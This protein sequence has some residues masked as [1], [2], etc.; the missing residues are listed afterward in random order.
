MV[1]FH[2]QNPSSRFPLLDV[3][4]WPYSTGGRS[5]CDPLLS[6]VFLK[7]EALHLGIG[8]G[9]Y[10]VESVDFNKLTAYQPASCRFRLLTAAIIF[11][12]ACSGRKIPEG[13]S[14]SAGIFWI[15]SL[16]VSSQVF[17]LSAL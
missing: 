10:Y 7:T 6:G 16:S 5:P 8:F 4:H 17:L 13:T 2:R 15:K 14:Y 9:P 3:F 11:G 1:T 12:R